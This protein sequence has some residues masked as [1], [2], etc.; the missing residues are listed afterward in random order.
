MRKLL[1]ASVA[2]C[3]IGTSFA[4]PAAQASPAVPGPTGPKCGYTAVSDPGPDAGPDAM[5]GEVHAGPLTWDRDFTVHCSLQRND[6]VHNGTS[7]DVWRESQGAEGTATTW[8]AHMPSRPVNYTSGENDRDYLCTSVTSA[9]GTIYWV[10]AEDPDGIPGTGDESGGYW[11]SDP[12]RACSAATQFSTG[13]L[14]DLINGIVIE[15]VD[16]TLCEA[17][18][19]LRTVLPANPL[20]LIDREGDVFIDSDLDGISEGDWQDDMFWDCEAYVDYPN[21]GNDGTPVIDP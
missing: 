19:A 14:I 18:K 4:V 1:L 8:V 7:N 16:P 2:L 15:F 13:P 17:L 12:N 20:V 21:P 5:T 10:G 6:N 3:A 11:T 9:G